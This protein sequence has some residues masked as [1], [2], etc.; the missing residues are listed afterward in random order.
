MPALVFSLLTLAVIQPAVAAASDPTLDSEERTLCQQINQYRMQNGRPAMRLSVSLT[1]AARWMSA[2]MATNNRF[3]HTDSLGRV[4][5]TRL[6]AFGYGF[7]ASKA[8]NIA[9]GSSSGASTF[10]QWKA[11]PAHAANMLSSTYV[12]M[13]LGRAYGASSTYKWYWT[14]DFGSYGD[15]TVPC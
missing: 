3:D 12:V 9:A 5:S 10:S 8:E 1:N 6:T 11:S 2:D 7:M 13:G 14:A 4:F 15:R